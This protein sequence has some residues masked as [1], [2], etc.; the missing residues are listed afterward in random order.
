MSILL[1]GSKVLH[2]MGVWGGGG[3][4]GLGWLPLSVVGF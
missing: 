2:G 3:A 4:L 1:F